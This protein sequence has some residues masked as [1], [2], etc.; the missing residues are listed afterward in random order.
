MRR[1]PVRMR[2]CGGSVGDVFAEEMHPARRGRKVAGDRVEQRR[3]AGAVGAEHRALLARRAPTATCRRSRAAR[4]SCASRRS[5]TS[6]SPDVAAIAH[7]SGQALECTAA[8]A[9]A[10]RSRRPPAPACFYGQ[11]GTSREPILNSAGVMPSSLV[12]VVDLARTLLNRPPLRVLHHF[13]D[14]RGADGLAVLV[15][16]DVA[17]RRLQRH[18]RQRLAVL[19]LAAATGRP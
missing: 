15:E 17:G 2:S 10:K 1:K 5:S 16:L 3:L 12:D 7:A 4:R 13:G 19:G 9:R 18:L 8:T 14:E 6:A 11:S